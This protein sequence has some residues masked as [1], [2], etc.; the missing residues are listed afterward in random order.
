MSAEGGDA[1][2]PPPPP[3]PPPTDYSVADQPVVDDVWGAPES[4]TPSGMDLASTDGSDA[5]GNARDIATADIPMID[6][7][8]AAPDMPD[9]AATPS[10]PDATAETAV[11]AAEAPSHLAPGAESG[12][13]SD[14][15][16]VRAD[17][18]SEHPDLYSQTDAPPP[19]VDGPHESPENWATEINPGSGNENCGD[20]ARAVEQTWEGNPQVASV[21]GPEPD[22]V[23]ADWAGASPEPTSADAI[24][25]RLNELGP[26]SSAIVGGNWEDG[27]GHWF[28]AVNDGGAIKAVDGQ[29]GQVESWPPSDSGLGFSAADMHNMEAI[30]FDASG[31][32]VR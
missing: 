32:V 24:N 27:G 30:F 11:P 18:A 23:M 9:A 12:T 1:P 25:E 20:C 22:S 13:D 21:G 7:G 29:S 16:G 15:T 26:G 19:Q 6:D 2:P 5:L 10:T 17:V 31:S 4:S 3:P 8:I 14:K 28:N